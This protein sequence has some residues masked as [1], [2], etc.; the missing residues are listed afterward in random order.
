[1]TSLELFF[2]MLCLLG[3]IA[4]LFIICLVLDICYAHHIL[5]SMEEEKN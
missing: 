5:R 3:V 4:V 2:C 1:M